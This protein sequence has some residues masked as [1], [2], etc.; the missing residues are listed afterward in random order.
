MARCVIHSSS[1]LAL[2]EWG[3]GLPGYILLAPGTARSEVL[4]LIYG[5]LRAGRLDRGAAGSLLT[6][7]AEEKVRYLNDRV[8]RAKALETALELGLPDTFLA[9]YA[10]LARLHADAL[11]I[12]DGPLREAVR[13]AVKTLTLGQVAGE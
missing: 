1:L 5:R 9:E 13:E 7:L 8:L 2:L 10:A 4:N 6:R 11:V 3:T 12:E